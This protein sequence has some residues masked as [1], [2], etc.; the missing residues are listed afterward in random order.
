MKEKGN[1]FLGHKKVPNHFPLNLPGKQTGA[2]KKT[3]I[4]HINGK[5]LL[6]KEL[7]MFPIMEIIKLYTKNFY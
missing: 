2:K 5:T 6:V 4:K 1:Y 7:H 3:K